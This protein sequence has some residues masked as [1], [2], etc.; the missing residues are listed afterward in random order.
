M[1]EEL[2]KDAGE[3]INS[4]LSAAFNTGE[5]YGVIQGIGIGL[6]LYHECT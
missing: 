3:E 1:A 2:G 6:R 5:Y 4:S